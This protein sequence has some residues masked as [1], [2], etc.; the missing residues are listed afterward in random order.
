MIFGGREKGK[1][2]GKER[3]MGRGKEGEGI[4]ESGRER[5]EAEQRRKGQ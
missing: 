4:S 3:A 5:E 2:S 1:V